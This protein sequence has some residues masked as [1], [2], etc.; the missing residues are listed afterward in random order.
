MYTSSE[1]PLVVSKCVA[2][3]LESKVGLAAS[4][5]LMRYLKVSSDQR[6]NGKGLYKTVILLFKTCITRCH[7]TKEVLHIR[8]PKLNHSVNDGK[9]VRVL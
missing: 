1:E 9:T 5:D 3:G 8:N 2:T 4:V 6:L 7:V